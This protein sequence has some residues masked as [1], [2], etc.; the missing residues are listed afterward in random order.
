LEIQR[1]RWPSSQHWGGSRE[2]LIKPYPGK[3]HKT[4]Q[5][6]LQNN[7]SIPLKL[8]GGTN[9]LFYSLELNS[10]FQR[11]IVPLSLALPRT[12]AAIFKISLQ[13]GNMGLLVAGLVVVILVVL[14]AFAAGYVMVAR[15]QMAID[16]RLR[17][18]T[19]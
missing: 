9:L 18:F 16:E 1:A 3:A 10:A 13:G 19:Q 17:R 11:W 7:K 2:A 14:A 4:T 15:E 5:G 6:F 8:L 12:L